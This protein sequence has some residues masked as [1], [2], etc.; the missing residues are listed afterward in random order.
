M[1]PTIK[2]PKTLSWHLIMP[3]SIALI[4]SGIVL[5]EIWSVLR[6]VRETKQITTSIVNYLNNQNQQKP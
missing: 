2:E 3:I 1:E 6:D 4:V 5:F